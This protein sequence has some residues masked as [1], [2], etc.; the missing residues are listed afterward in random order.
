VDMIVAQGIEA[1]GHVAGEVGGMAL[2]PQVVDAV[3]PTPVVAA[4]GISDA[5]GIVAALALGAEAVMLGTRFIPCHESLAH[6]LYKQKILEAGGDDTVRTTLF[7]HGWPH[8]PHRTLRTPFV[9]RWLSDEARGS[10]ERPDEPVV[11]ATKIAGQE[12]PLQRFVGFPPS[13]HTT[14]D[15]DSMNYL[16]GQGVGLVHHV[17]PAADIVHELCTQAQD[18]IRSMKALD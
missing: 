1:G 2:V 4:G 14:G 9:E 5:R 18:I 3:V 15:M 13:V 11:G 6:P 12:V 16:A 7:G 8:A 17:Q 10:E